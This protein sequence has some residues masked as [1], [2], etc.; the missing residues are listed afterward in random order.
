MTSHSDAAPGTASE[1]GLQV[2]VRAARCFVRAKCWGRQVC[3]C[4][5]SKCTSGTCR[6]VTQAGCEP[7]LG[8]SALE[9][10]LDGLPFWGSQS[11]QMKDAR[12]GGWCEVSVSES[13]RASQC[14]H[15]QAPIRSDCEISHSSGEMVMWIRIRGSCWGSFPTCTGS[16]GGLL[17]CSPGDRKDNTPLTC[18]GTTSP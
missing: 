17:R 4:S 3:S 5:L 8:V 15:A 12:S 2:P 13:D 7:A 14:Q 10:V 9:E 6:L 18:T 1:S 16:S 11:C